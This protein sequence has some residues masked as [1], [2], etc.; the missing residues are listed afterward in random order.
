MP[1]EIIWEDK[2]VNV[3][4]FEKCTSEDLINSNLKLYEHPNFKVAVVT[5]QLV[6]IGLANMYKVFFE[7]IGNDLSR[8]T[9]IFET[10]EDARKWIKT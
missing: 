8:E 10:I 5:N 9:Q 1:Y 7:I 2:R 3:I 6:V 4:F